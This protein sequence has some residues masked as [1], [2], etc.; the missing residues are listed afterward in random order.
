MS[1]TLTPARRPSKAHALRLHQTRQARVEPPRPLGEDAA[2][3]IVEFN[4]TRYGTSTQPVRPFLVEAIRLSNLTGTENIRK[5]CRYLS[6]LAVFCDTQGLRLSIETVLTTNVIEDYIRRGTAEWAGEE[7][8]LLRPIRV[9][10]A[11][12]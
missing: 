4:F 1:A 9:A 7:N 12:P 8:P 2:R 3:I 11:L 6:A 10:H 5:H